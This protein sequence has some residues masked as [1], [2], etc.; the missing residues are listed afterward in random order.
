MGKQVAGEGATF[1]VVLGLR[2]ACTVDE[3][4]SKKVRVVCSPATASMCVMGSDVMILC[5]E[6]SK[7]SK[8]L[9]N[10]NS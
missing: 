3:E 4:R 9:Q 5:M 6:K 8:M 1:A 2:D 7:R 10:L